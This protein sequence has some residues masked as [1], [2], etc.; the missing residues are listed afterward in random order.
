VSEEI[1]ASIPK[2][3]CATLEPFK[4]G[5]VGIFDGNKLTQEVPLMMARLDDEANSN[6]KDHCQEGVEVTD[7]VTVDW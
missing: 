2:P 3:L 4:D 7:E 6:A 5:V 1:A